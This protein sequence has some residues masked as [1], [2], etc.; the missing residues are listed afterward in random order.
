MAMSVITL[1]L[2]LAVAVSAIAALSAADRTRS[3]ISL[4]IAGLL[5]SAIFL[6]RSAPDLALV[7]LLATASVVIIL[8]RVVVR[9]EKT[10]VIYPADTLSIAAV[11]LAAGVV[12]TVLFR[13]VGLLPQST[14]A[15]LP[16][17][18]S[19]TSFDLL[20]TT[21]P[22]DLIAISAIFLVLILGAVG[23][24]RRGAEE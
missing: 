24:L 8:T 3:A 13:Q 5:C 18:G 17:G 4:A 22:I 6:L 12:A 21:R 11:F 10:I 20:L 2:V 16:G 9:L 19:L 1:T 7:N 23:S 14:T 15:G